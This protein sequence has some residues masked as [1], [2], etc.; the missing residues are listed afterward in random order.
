VRCARD[1]G[2]GVNAIA[3]RL[4]SRARSKGAEEAEVY[5]SRGSEFTVKVFKGEVESLVS[6]ESRGL[7]LRTFR[8]HRVGFAYTSDTDPAS[9]DELVDEALHNGRY[10]HADDANVLPDPAPIEELTGMYAP[11]LARL[12]PQRKVDF[13]LELERVA[14]GLDPRVRRLGDAVYSD[15]A[16]HVELTNTRGFDGAF[17]RSVAYGVVDAIAEQDGEMQ[18]GFAFTYG[19]DLDALDLAAVTKEAV[20]HAVGLLGARRVKTAR[21]PVVLHPHAAAML[22]GVIGS[23]FSGDAVL[24]RRSLLAG[25]VGQS[26]ASTQVAIVDDARLPTGLASRPFDGEGVRA[27][28]VDLIK[29]GVLRG[30]LQN[31]Y[32]ARR[33]GE[34]STGSAVRSYKSVPE[35]GVTN[36]VLQPGVESREALLGRVKSGLHVEQLHGL[37][38][39]NPVSGEFSFGLTGHWIRDGQL[40]EPVRELTVA[41]NLIGL[42]TMIVALADDLRFL[43]AGGFC[44]CPTVLIEELAIGG[45]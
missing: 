25:K 17:D 38:T 20:D 2:D 5:V 15:G 32:T 3:E 37:N 4:L 27:R 39:V 30:Y 6:A 16:G 45:D 42:L 36:L 21:V 14:I 29:D 9:L 35:V 43:F 1:A 40:A 22:L 44:G 33:S 19:R 23:S 26:V 31:T 41:G 28:R 18:S 12:D 13:A 10:N 11:E 34:Q 24:K 7:G 8:E